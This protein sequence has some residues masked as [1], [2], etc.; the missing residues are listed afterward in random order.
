MNSDFDVILKDVTCY[1]NE[2]LPE[3][4]TY[5]NTEHTLYVLEKAIHIANKEKVSSQELEL[6]K[7]GALYHDIGFTKTHIDHEKVSCEIARIQ[8]KNYNYSEEEI[9]TICGMIM[10]TKIP[11]KPKNLLEKII[12]D[13]D[14]EYLATSSFWSTSKLL[15]QELRYL[16]GLTREQWDQIQ[17]KFIKDHKFHTSYCKQYKEFRKLRNLVLLESLT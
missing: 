16:E 10:A 14:L 3:Y 15:F 2:N 13:A 7:I 8:L 4:L 9:N 5:H 11:Q 1:L 6:I 17:I 12:A